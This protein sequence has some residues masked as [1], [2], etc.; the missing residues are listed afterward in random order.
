MQGGILAIDVA[1]DNANIV[2][3]AGTDGAVHLFDRQDQ[4]ILANLSKHSKKVTGGF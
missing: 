4:R 2:A 3:T 1:P